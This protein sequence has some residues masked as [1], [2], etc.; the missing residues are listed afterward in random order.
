MTYKQDQARAFAERI[1]ALG[2]A[3]YLAQDHEYGF[4]TDST[5]SR[6]LSFGF[7]GGE[8]LGGN[9]GPPSTSC[10]TGWRMDQLPSGLRTKDDVHAALYAEPPDWLYRRGK[11]W[12]YLSTVAHYL[13][14]YQKS[15][16]FE[17]V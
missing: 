10:G 3:V 11:G 7:M 17:R 13:D 1:K 6:V 8:N 16:K 12:K 2:F 15:S 14:A 9:Y 4:I 5:E